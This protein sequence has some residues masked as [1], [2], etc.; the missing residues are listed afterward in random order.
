MLQTRPRAAIHHSSW[1][2]FCGAV[3]FLQSAST[4]AQEA[5]MCPS[6]IPT[7]PILAGVLSGGGLILGLRG[8]LAKI[9]APQRFA[10]ACK[11]KN[12]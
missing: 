11:E 2:V 9:R 7:M 10:V 3:E 12:A 1:K 6:C 5:E 4:I 8:V